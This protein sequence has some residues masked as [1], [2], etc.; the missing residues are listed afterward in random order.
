MFQL[1]Q[2]ITR[3]RAK[4]LTLGFTS[5]IGRTARMERSCKHIASLRVQILQGVWFETASR[6]SFY[7]HYPVG[8]AADKMGVT[9]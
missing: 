5:N 6:L 2:F 9:A 8:D 7:A 3:P 4:L 1:K